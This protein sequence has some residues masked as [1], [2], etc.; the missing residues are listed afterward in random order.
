MNGPTTSKHTESE[1]KKKKSSIK[2]SPGP[3][4]FT[5]KFYKI[6][7]QGLAV[8]FLNT[9]KKLKRRENHKDPKYPEKS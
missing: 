1:I 7:T 4:S 3:D 5:V 2:K 6:F 8:I 9:S